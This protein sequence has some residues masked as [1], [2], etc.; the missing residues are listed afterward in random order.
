LLLLVLLPS[1]SS[2]TDNS[3]FDEDSHRAVFFIGDVADNVIRR[4]FN[5]T[6]AISFVG[7]DDSQFAVNFVDEVRVVAAAAAADTVI[8]A[9][10]EAVISD[11]IVNVRPPWP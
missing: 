6:R 10:A 9:A 11:D 5:N 3:S 1:S 7:G 8:A 2:P 4:V